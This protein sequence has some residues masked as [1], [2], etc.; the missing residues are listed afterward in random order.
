MNTNQLWIDLENRSAEWLDALFRDQVGLDVD[1]SEIERYTQSVISLAEDMALSYRDHSDAWSLLSNI[2][3]DA[4]L[5][6]IELEIMRLYEQHYTYDDILLEGQPVTPYSRPKYLRLENNP[7]KRHDI[8]T[9]VARGHPEVDQVL[10]RHNAKK[11]ELATEW[12]YTPID[13]FLVSEELNLEQL[14]KL[15][16]E[17]ASAMRHPFESCFAENREAVLGKNQGEPWEDFITLYMNRWSEYVDRFIPTIDAV[18]T[19]H[20]IAK[21]MGF[22]VDKITIDLDDRPRKVPGASAWDIRIPDDVRICVKPVGGAENLVSIHHE[23]GH[24]LH[25]VS[26]DPDLPYYI[27]SGNSSGITETFSFWMES[28]VSEPIYLKE[29]GL[30]ERAITELVRFEQLVRSTFS[31][32]LSAQALCIIDYWT[33]GPFTLDEIGEYLSHYVEQFMGFSVPA[34]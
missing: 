23:M 5:T 34:N 28:L 4:K 17:I 16:M 30:S 7:E 9:R 14:R 20:K 27:R 11:R 25:F 24:A 19:T 1:S 22:D 2:L 15:L 8:L 21:S 13:D 29:L 32:W 31:T 33:E 10:E 3:A 26:I 6:T 12:N 18:N